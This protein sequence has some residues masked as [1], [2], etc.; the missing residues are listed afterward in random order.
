MLMCQFYAWNQLQNKTDYSVVIFCAGNYILS[1]RPS[2]SESSLSENEAG[3][4]DTRRE[5]AHD[6]SED[7]KGAKAVRVSNLFE[8]FHYSFKKRAGGRSGDYKFGTGCTLDSCRFLQFLGPEMHA[9]IYL[10]GYLPW[11]NRRVNRCFTLRTC[12]KP[13]GFDWI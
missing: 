8:K 12:C 3:T 5:S 11:G 1:I 13:Q 7:V 9:F 6:W 4:E 2:P 10:R